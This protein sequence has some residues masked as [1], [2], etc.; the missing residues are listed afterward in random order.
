M[1]KIGQINK[2]GLSVKE[3]KIGLISFLIAFLIFGA[4]YLTGHFTTEPI[5]I[6]KEGKIVY[7]YIKPNVTSYQELKDCYDS[8]IS[9]DGE[10]NK[11]VFRVRAYD[12]CK[13]SQKD[14]RLKVGSSGNWK[15]YVGGALGVAA[16]IGI[17]YGVVKLLE[18]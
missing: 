10:I 6:V 13:E 17:T 5:E 12:A 18:K 2:R 15:F 3:F 4:G 11:K 9:I 16:G 7:K 8:R 1:S 14:F